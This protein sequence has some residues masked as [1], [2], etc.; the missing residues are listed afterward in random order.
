MNMIIFSYKGKSIQQAH[1]HL[2][3]TNMQFDV[4]MVNFSNTL[5]ELGLEFGDVYYIV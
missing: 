4:T 3:I 5:T 2:N 1:Q